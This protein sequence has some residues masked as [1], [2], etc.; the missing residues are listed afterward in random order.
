VTEAQRVR[1]RAARQQGNSFRHSGG[2]LDTVIVLREFLNKV[3]AIQGYCASLILAIILIACFWPCIGGGK[4]LLASAQDEPSILFR[5][6]EQ[7]PDVDRLAPKTG[8]P[9]AAAWQTEP[10]FAFARDQYRQGALPL[11]NPYQAYGAPLAA[12]MQS[13]PFYPLTLAL[14]L[15]LTPRTYSFYLLA[16]LFVAAIC[17]YFY[18]RRFVSFL[19]AIAGGIG[20]MLGG[21]Y[22]VF[23][24]MP[25]LSVE[26]L[27]PAMLLVTEYLPRHQNYRS[28]VW[29]A[30]VVALVILGGM[31]ESALLLLVFAAA[32]ALFRVLS[33]AERTPHPP[34]KRNPEVFEL[35]FWIW[36]A[37]DA[38]L[39]SRRG[40]EGR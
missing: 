19:A 18:L 38:P 7:A 20:C 40:T 12:N 13:Q 24:N 11:W 17:A 33:E 23:L 39:P 15:R 1:L 3:A 27:L 4:T 9:G 32:Y 36:G 35:S 25:H 5:G 37:C 2:A 26:T 34:R 8:D 30:V 21:Y 28:V 29:L 16:R 22:I 10:W 31:P 6:A 14:F